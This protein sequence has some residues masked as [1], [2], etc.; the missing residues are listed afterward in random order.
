MDPFTTI[1]LFLLG[2]IIGSFLTVC[3]YRIP[4]GREDIREE[5]LEAGE[6]IPLPDNIKAEEKLSV[7][8]PKRSFCPSCGAQLE[9]YHNIPLF[10]WL[11]LLGKCAFCKSKIPFRY[12]FVELLTAS[13]A[14]LSYSYFGAT[15]EAF[16]V[17]VFLASLI[18]MSFIDIDYYILPD[19]ITLPGATIG[20][21][22]AGINEFTPFFGEPFSADLLDALFGVLAGA[23]TLY[24]VSEVYFRLRKIEGLGHG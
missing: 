13:A 21:L 18:V 2:A 17:F 1:F 9:W 3:I 10:S 24:L 16:L 23:G 7:G 22:I 5:I 20:L 15:L 8:F 4:L 12:F 6:E 11:F 14:I 19:I